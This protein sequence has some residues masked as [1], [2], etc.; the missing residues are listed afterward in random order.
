[1]ARPCWQGGAENVT[2]AHPRW[3]VLLRS[4][5]RYSLSSH[6]SPTNGWP[7]PSYGS[8][9]ISLKPRFA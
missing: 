6:V 8:D 7:N 4:P 2:L 1:M 9:F 5:L 3:A